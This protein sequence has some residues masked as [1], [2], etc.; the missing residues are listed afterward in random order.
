MSFSIIIP[1]QE[2]SRHHEKGDLAPFGDTTLLQWK[3]AQ[4]KEFAKTSQIYVNSESQ[5]IKNIVEE[6]G[7]NFIQRTTNKSYLD[8]VYNS[9][10][11]VDGDNIIWL[12]CTAPFLDGKTIVKMRDKF[13]NENLE[14]LVTVEKKK[15]YI[16]YNN[17]QLN[18][19]NIFKSRVEIEPVYIMTNSCYII[20]KE[21]A[22]NL[23]SLLNN[24]PTFYELDS[25]ESIEINDVK[26]YKMAKEMINIYF[27]REFL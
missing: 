9:I 8:V 11:K 22:L 17:K 23:K 14:S 4:C 19:E 21:L 6:E 12:N 7:V 3:I 24:N 1:A 25:F 27:K 18:F 2:T 13:L 20:K 26:D 10:S 16:F 15:E 5:T